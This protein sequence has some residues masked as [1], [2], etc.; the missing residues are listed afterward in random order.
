MG[1]ESS[2]P[3][4][5]SV[6]LNTLNRPTFTVCAAVHHAIMFHN[7]VECLNV[8]ESGHHWDGSVVPN[9]S[10]M[11]VSLAVSVD[12]DTFTDLLLLAIINNIIHAFR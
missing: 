10:L 11:A 1:M 12:T 8:M 6:E 3:D 4:R 9:E 7:N 5:M 2:R